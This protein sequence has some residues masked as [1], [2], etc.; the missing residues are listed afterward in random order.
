[1][2][3][4]DTALATEVAS[5]VVKATIIIG[6]TL[7]TL[8][9]TRK[10]RASLRHMVLATLFAVLLALPMASTLTPSAS[11]VQVQIPTGRIAKS[12][13]LASL[14][15]MTPSTDS[16]RAVSGERAKFP[17]FR[18]SASM[19]LLTVWGTGVLLF[20]LPVFVGLWKVHRL[21]RSG[22]PWTR[23]QSVL[24]QLA[25]D[26]DVRRRV[27][28]LLHGAVSG[29]GSWGAFRPII[30]LPLDAQNWHEDDIVRA[31]IHELEHVRRSDWA[32]QCLARV[33]CACYW[34]HPL[35]WI[36]WR[37]LTLEAERASDDAVLLCADA[38]AYADQLVILAGRMSNPPSRALITMTGRSDLAARVTAILNVQQ[39]RGRA[40]MFSMGLVCL[41]SILLVALL[42]PIGIAAAAQ[43]QAPSHSFSGSLRDP[44]GRILSDTSLTL[45][46]VS[47]RQRVEARSDQSGHFTFGEIPRG[48]YRLQVSDFGSQGEMIFASRE[49]LERDIAVVMPGVDDELTVY[50]SD[51]SNHLPPPPPPL[52]LP[53]ST[54][55]TYSSQPDLDRCA[56]VSMFCRVTPPVQIARVQPI[57]PEKK[58]EGGVASTV[59]L[60]GRVGTD[61]LIKDLHTTS[62]ADPD[63]AHAT[64]DALHCWQFTPIRFDGVPV[65]MSIRVTA[66]F[67]V[68]KSRAPIT[69]IDLVAKILRRPK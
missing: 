1:M 66:H 31:I 69:S 60:E 37:Q 33:V 42:S 58:R 50:S 18:V 54:S 22:Q 2:T 64:S 53:L 3:L 35:V 17:Y 24:Q 21:R 28:V 14:S 32:I 9:L 52:P 44:L 56:Q 25:V 13:T 16:V 29:P 48:E 12:P 5:I 19:L 43:I 63:F 55:Q 34:F 59:V 46:N 68:R 27:E 4:A 10:S 61:G 67:V 40:G 65:A 45:L 7:A 8:R 38:T 23:G 51:V 39:Q 20:L 62:H 6:L 36:A 57:Y 41:S 26:A 49:H 11:V 30:A 47:T 15:G